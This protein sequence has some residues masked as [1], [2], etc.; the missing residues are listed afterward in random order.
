MTSGPV[1]ASFDTYEDLRRQADLAL[2]ECRWE[3]ASVLF[4]RALQQARQS[5]DEHLADRACCNLSIPK[6]ELGEGK[7]CLPQLR[8]ILI[9]TA[10]PVN[11]Y[12]AAYNLAYAYEKE[13]RVDKGLFYA[14]IALGHAEAAGRAEWRAAA[15]NSIANLYL[16][17]SRT[18]PAM[19]AY[20]AALELLGDG[21]SAF[22][23]TLLGNLGYCH[24]LDGRL[25]ESFR[26]LYRSW[27]MLRGGGET[28]ALMSFRLDLA[29][30]HLEAD[31]PRSAGRHARAALETAHRLSDAQAAKNALYILGE[32]AHLAGDRQAATRYFTELQGFYPDL[33]V[34]T[35]FLLSFDV[36]KLINLRA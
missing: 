8:E 28:R 27:R 32:S 6:I 16:I 25:E 17:D 31:R 3:E 1:Q 10:D 14:R 30:A 18:A 24:L 12:L 21:P 36:R 9:R 34:V 26:L 7:T 13:K 11:R 19:E 15:H 23:G 29:F 4:E 35:D 5:G 20:R 2:R 33:P 22:V